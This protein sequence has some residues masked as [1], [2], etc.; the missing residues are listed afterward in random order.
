MKPSE[1]SQIEFLKDCIRQGKPREISFQEFSKKF[2]TKGLTTDR[3]IDS[4]WKIAKEAI[5][6]EFDYIAAKVNEGIEKAIK[7]RTG[8]IMGIIERQELLTAIGRGEL[9][10]EQV[11]IDKGQPKK[12]KVKPTFNDMKGGIAELNK[13]DGSY[14]P[15]KTDLTTNGKDLQT[16][17]FTVKVS[18]ENSKKL[19]GL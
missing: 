13:M 7:E 15:A 4:R 1:Y 17:S 3:T 19:D 18:E 10:Q 9:E 11:F 16:V 2:K 8:K 14:A 6:A 5:Q 12:I